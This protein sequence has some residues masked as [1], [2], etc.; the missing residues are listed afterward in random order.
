M[1]AQEFAYWLKGYFELLSAGPKTGEKVTLTVEQIEMIQR[2]LNYVFAEKI[3]RSA[4]AMPTAG[5]LSEAILQASG[6][7]KF[8]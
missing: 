5:G 2:H 1:T 8:C 6:G 7:P 4:G 3:Q